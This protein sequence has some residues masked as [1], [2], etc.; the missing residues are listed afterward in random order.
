MLLVFGCW[1]LLIMIGV[2]IGFSMAIIASGF[3]ILH[4]GVLLSIPQRILSGPDSIPILAIPFFVFAGLLMN[5]SGITERIYRFALALVGHVRGSLGHV[6]VIAS[7]IFAGMSGSGAAEAA[8]LG[9]IEMKALREAGFDDDFNVGVVLSGATI[10]P[11]IPPSI[12][13]VLYGTLAS[14]SVG[15][16]FAGGFIPGILMGASLSAMVYIIARKRNYPV[17]KRAT[18]KEVGWS[19]LG[20]LWALLTPLM[21]LSGIFFGIVTP[22]EAAIGT[23]AYALFLGTV[24]YRKLTW[25][26]LRETL[27]DTIE[28]TAVVILIISCAN[29]FA[30]MLTREQLP[31]MIASSLFAISRNPVVVLF[32]INIF[33]LIVGCFMEGLAAM[34]ILVPILLPVLKELGI[35]PV[36]F[37]VVMTLNL[38]I[39][40]LTPPVGTYLYIMTRV[41]K[42][43]FEDVVKAVLPW[44]V[45]LVIVLMLISFFPELVLWLPRALGFITA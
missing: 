40:A 43:S 7:M 31:Q 27:L 5:V 28:T 17:Y 10:G 23:V 18:L 24:V 41:A 25:K 26:I 29:L 3:L 34:I 6:N 39:G 14:A 13:F 37:G 44:C 4:H 38:T 30:W 1:F 15:A 12:P 16:L 11:I 22:T 32:L 33:L 35:H 42:M 2:P 9:V 20:A 19:F 8:G 21:I 36:H 45:P